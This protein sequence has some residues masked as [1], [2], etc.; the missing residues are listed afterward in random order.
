MQSTTFDVRTVA[1]VRD[2]QVEQRTGANG[3]FESKS[4]L[5]R[6]AVD[7]PYKVTRQENGKTIS[8]SPTDFW[9]AKATGNTAQAIHDYCTAKKEDGKLVSRHLLLSGNFENYDSPRKVKAILPVNIN[10]VMYN[11]E[12]EVDVPNNKATIFIVSE[13]KFL[14]SNPVNRGTS[15]A[16]TATAQAVATPVGRAGQPAQTVGQP[17]QAT[18]TAQQNPQPVQ[19]APQT[20]QSVNPQAT[21]AGTV[22][23]TTATAQAT[24]Q[25]TMA[26]AMNVPTVGDG[27]IPEGQTAPF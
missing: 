7:R 12:G 25:Q 5:F 3:T 17:V 6:I 2:L 18:A 22:Q 26:G 9:L 11:V 21:S 10:G 20:V 19:A 24:A 15:T 27:F 4:I 14:D 1:I 16:A 23:G 8:E 13:M